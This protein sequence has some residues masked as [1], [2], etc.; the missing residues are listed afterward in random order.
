[1]VEKNV[2]AFIFQSRRR[3]SPLWS[4]VRS[5]ASPWRPPAPRSTSSVAKRGG[6]LQDWSDR[7][8]NARPARSDSASGIHHGTAGAR[9]GLGADTTAAAGSTLIVVGY[10]ACHPPT[11]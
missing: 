11:F 8:D 7:A 5:S 6:R 10:C 2:N 3:T 9:P 1:M 4:R